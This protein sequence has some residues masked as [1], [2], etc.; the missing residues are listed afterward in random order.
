MSKFQR[1]V[2]IDTAAQRRSNHIKYEEK[3]SQ[4]DRKL[5]AQKPPPPVQEDAVPLWP[6]ELMKHI[7]NGK[8]KEPSVSRTDPGPQSMSAI[9]QKA[10]IISSPDIVG[11][12]EQPLK[13]ASPEASK[14]PAESPTPLY[15]FRAPVATK[16]KPSSLGMRS[17]PSSPQSFSSRTSGGTEKE[18][19]SR[20]PK[21]R[22]ID[23]KV[24]HSER[25]KDDGDEILLVTST[26]VL[27][28]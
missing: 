21:Q 13:P 12:E 18:K 15:S 24:R 25:G 11:K 1:Y 4:L 16:K 27:K 17:R 5:D 3:R 9:P 7:K 14:Q 10:V 2:G 28:H 8:H 19:S 20:T 22:K 6:G 26:T 23:Q